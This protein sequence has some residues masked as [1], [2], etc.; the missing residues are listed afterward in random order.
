MD[1]DANQLSALARKDNEAATVLLIELFHERLYA[2]LR[3]LAGNDSDAEDLTQ[4]TFSRVQRALPSF[5]GRSSVSSWVHSIGYHVYVDWQRGRRPTEGRTAEWWAECV[6]PE[7]SPDETAARTDLARQLFIRVD[8][9]A[10][11]LRDSVHLHYYQGLTLQETADAM[12]IATSTVKYRLR[13]AL[14]ELQKHFAAER[15]PSEP[16]NPLKA[17]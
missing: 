3:R 17:V 15:R 16:P 13:Q 11:D 8:R 10:P 12:D 7:I 1:L 4:Q 14:D 2:F 6:S 9:L 5:A